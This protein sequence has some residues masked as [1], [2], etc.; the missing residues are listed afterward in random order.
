MMISNINKK[1]VLVKDYRMCKSD[2]SK[3]IGLMFARKLKNKALAFAFDRP[4]KIALHMFFVFQTIDIL[5]L[6][7]NRKIVELKQN[8]KPFTFFSFENK[9]NLVLELPEGTLEKTG[10]EV[11]DEI[12]LKQ[13]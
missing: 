3:A 2:W 13:Q 11:G 10:T 6:D 4:K 5:L 1:K 8:F 9:A 7:E 12:E